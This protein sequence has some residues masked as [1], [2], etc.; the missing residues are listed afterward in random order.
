M[1]LAYNF[2]AGELLLAFDSD[3]RCLPDALEFMVERWRELSLHHSDLAGIVT[4]CITSDGRPLGTPFP[5]DGEVGHLHRVYD[6]LRLRGDRWDI[7]LTSVLRQFP[8]P[9]VAGQRLC[10]EGL[11]WNRISRNYTMA[12]FN[13]ATRIHEYLED[14][15]TA[16]LGRARRTSPTLFKVYHEEALDLD[17]SLLSKWRA[18]SNYVR[19]SIHEKSVGRSFANRPIA[20]ACGAV[21]GTA[22]AVTDHVLDG[23][24]TGV[25]ATLYA[26]VSARS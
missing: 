22:L 24:R 17:I 5:T 3:D 10:P 21:V 9:M 11:V 20:F 19:A 23:R 8:F 13:H 6:R 2:A 12:F 26:F 15:Y 1:N 7:H 16:N 4:S 25:L 18:A 14:G